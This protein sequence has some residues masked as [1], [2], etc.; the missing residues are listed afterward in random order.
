MTDLSEKLEE[1]IDKKIES[2]LPKPNQGKAIVLETDIDGTVWVRFDGG[3][4]RTPVNSYGVSFASGDEVLVRIDD[5]GRA[6]IDTNYSNPG[7]GVTQVQNVEKNV[8]D[9][10]DKADTA[11][12]SADAAEKAAISAIESAEEASEAASSAQES[13]EEAASAAASAQQ[14]ATEADDKATDAL[15]SAITA[16]YNANVAKQNASQA[17][18]YAIGALGSL[19]DVEKV[20]GTLN[21]ITEHGVWSETLDEHVEPGKQYYTFDDDDYSPVQNPTD[22]GMFSYALT[23]DVEIDPEKTYYERVVEYTYTLTQDTEI[24]S[25]KTYYEQVV[26]YEYELTQDVELDPTKTYYVLIE[27]EYV[28]VEEPD[29]ADIGSY[30]EQSQEVSYDAVAEPDEEDF[31]TYYERTEHINYEVVGKN[32]LKNSANPT[33]DDVAVYNGEIV[34]DGTI[35]LEPTDEARACAKWKV[36]YLDY[37]DYAGDTYTFSFDA[38]ITDDATMYI[39]DIVRLRIAVN[40]ASRIPYSLSASYDAY[41]I[42]SPSDAEN[43]VGVDWKTYT[44]TCMVPEDL[45]SGAQ[46]TLSAGNYLTAEAYSPPMTKPML[47]KNLKLERGEKATSADITEYYERTVLYYELSV[48][49]SV[50]NYIANHL[51]LTNDGLNLTADSSKYRAVLATDGLRILDPQG[52][53]V[54]VHGEEVQL[55]STSGIYF[56]ATSNILSFRTVDQLIAWFGQNSDGIW[57]MHIQNTYAEDMVR[58]GDYAFIKRQNGNMSLKWLGDDS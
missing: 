55:G 27:G 39:K 50:Q 21:W 35:K 6:Y 49:V 18:A 23:S 4:D 25:G 47:V 1:L 9:V 36:D 46:E 37:A 10:S 53:V 51:S 2:A 16:D 33:S 58:F 11:L 52:N 30:Y 43:Q 15:A 8:A 32:L 42:T 3:A 20:V 7:A 13:A 34:G 56:S 45:V 22:D 41:Y 5:G 44:L 24:V 19:S 12:Q 48:D 57:E 26:T 29:V 54:G 14:S 28:L 17:N 31:Q 40:K 38:K